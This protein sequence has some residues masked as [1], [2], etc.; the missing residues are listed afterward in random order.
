MDTQQ[1]PLSAPAADTTIGAATPLCTGRKRGP[2]AKRRYQEGLFRRENGHFY[3]FFYRDK[4]MPDGATRSR[5][6]RINLAV[7][8]GPAAVIAREYADAAAAAA[9]AADAAD[10]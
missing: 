2:V 7:G 5:L 6:V 1:I 9:A 10:L 3:S 8:E 4:A